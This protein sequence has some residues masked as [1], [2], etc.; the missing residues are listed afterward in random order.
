MWNFVYHVFLKAYHL[1]VFLQRVGYLA[2]GDCVCYS[3][4]NTLPIFKNTKTY[5]IKAFKV[6]LELFKKLAEQRVICE[7]S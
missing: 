7:N 5:E 1:K 4:L 6:V 3:M 2:V